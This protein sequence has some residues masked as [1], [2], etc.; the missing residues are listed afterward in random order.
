MSD[1][2]L[3]LKGIVKTFPG[4]KA[5]NGVN[6]QIRPGEVHALLGENGAGKSTLIKVITGIH[7]PDQ[8][9]IKIFGKQVKFSG[10]LQAQNCGIAA[11]YQDP[12]VF[13][14][15]KVMENVYMGHHPTFPFFKRIDWRR[16]RSETTDLFKSL[17]MDIDPLAPMKSLS[18]AERQLVEIAKAL[19]F[20]SKILIMDEPTSALTLQEVQELFKI[21]NRLRENGTA[22][23]YISHRLEEAFEIADRVTV[24]RDGQYIDTQNIS[25]VTMDQLIQMMVG[26]K[27]SALFPKA[28]TK[29]G[30]QVLEVKKL[31]KNGEFSD[32]SFELYKGEIVGLAGLVGAGRTELARTI[33]GVDRI[34]G[35]EIIIEGQKVSIREPDDALK[36]GIAYLP[37]DRQQYGLVF[38][39]TITQNIT[40]PTLKKFALWGHLDRGKEDLVSAEY[41]KLL[42]IRTAGLW[43]K[44]LQLSGGNQQKVVLAKWLSTKPKVLILDEPTKGVDVGAKAAIYKIISELAAEGMAIL[45]ISSE[46][47]EILGMSDRI[48]VMHEGRLT[49]HFMR[50]EATQEKILA[51]ATG[52]IGHSCNPAVSVT[53]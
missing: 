25:D 10:T 9:E 11:I 22:I 53:R 49:A 8:G 28:E 39:M 50:T 32:I 33:F 4:V 36:N 16:M 12:T 3:E 1:F 47:P 27:L 2:I 52:R 38:P 13:P 15:L 48:L 44:A 6:L 40:L 17:E 14:D 23:I 46:L 26:R 21:I 41:I 20:N 19:S 29:R 45:M 5:L 24:L 37:E 31:T 30:R 35:G 18:V 34:D 42:D 7:Q 43:Q 51:S